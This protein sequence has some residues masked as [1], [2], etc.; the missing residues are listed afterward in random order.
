MAKNTL[1]DDILE[2]WASTDRELADQ[3]RNYWLNLSFYLGRQWLYWDRINRTVGELDDGDERARITINKIKPRMNGLLGRLTQANLTFEVPPSDSDDKTMMGARA[4]ENV[5]QHLH[6]EQ[7]WEGIRKENLFNV[8]LGGTAGIAVEWDPEAGEKLW[9]NDATDKVTGMGEASVVP[10]SIG[11]FSLQ[12]GVR[13]PS[14]AMWWIGCSALP[15]E[16]ARERWS[17]KST[18]MADGNT[19]MSPTHRKLLTERGA[20]ENCDLTLVY[21]LYERPSKKQKK[22]RVVVVIGG[23]TVRDEEWPFPFEHLNLRVFHQT[24]IP[25]QWTGDTFVNDTRSIQV[26]YNLAQSCI[27]EHAKLAGN[28]RL[29]VPIG[30]MADQQSLTDEP[31]EIISY[32][33]DGGA[34]PEWM[35]PAPLQRWL[36]QW[37]PD[38][39]RELDDIMHTHEVTRGMAPGDRN[40]GLALSILSEND[41]T[42]LGLMAHDQADGWGDVASMVMDCYA[43]KVKNENRQSVIDV[44][45]KVPLKFSWSSETLAGQT[46]VRVPLENTMP[47]SKVAT[48]AA[49][50]NLVNA[51]PQVAANLSG[52]AVLKLVGMDFQNLD[53]IVDADAAKAQHENVLMAVG[54]PQIPEKWHDHARHIAEHNEFRN[55]QGFTALEVDIQKLF[56]DHAQSHQRL[57]EEEALAQAKVNAAQPGM[58]A[59][60]QA[61]NPIGSAVPDTYAMQSAAIPPGAAGSAV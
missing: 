55:S 33:P 12:P 42:P 20:T 24:P 57:L 18:P 5:C 43:D 7:A 21:S 4:S 23:E 28:A 8:L 58:G 17:L 27:A 56:E 36:T 26:A 52:S 22:G 14:E 9:R 1:A 30:S 11:E 47:Q 10:M 54:K 50:T 51:F 59:L 6:A 49:I 15:P 31:G 35:A 46:R 29:L 34:K 41:A 53:S 3:R 32:Y 39:E 45:G 2:R 13:R 40:S 60:P 19:A 16:V 38:L 44:G 48:Q 25:G 37:A 61:D